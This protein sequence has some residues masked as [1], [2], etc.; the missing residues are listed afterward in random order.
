M[1]SQSIIIKLAVHRRPPDF[2][3]SDVKDSAVNFQCFLVTTV[4]RCNSVVS[5]P[6]VVI[7]PVNVTMSLLQLLLLHHGTEL[8]ARQSA[9]DV[10]C[11]LATYSDC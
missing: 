10:S 3:L 9:A 6:N 5:C 1:A 11:R 7:N 8:A 4:C 2:I